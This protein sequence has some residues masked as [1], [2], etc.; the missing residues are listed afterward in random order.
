MGLNCGTICSKHDSIEQASEE[1]LYLVKL[2]RDDG[3]RMEDALNDY[4]KEIKEL[5]EQI[6]YKDIE[7]ED[8]K[9][10]LNEKE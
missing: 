10:K 3:I 6:K 8:L 7:I 9:D 1:I 4:K 5:K 2:A